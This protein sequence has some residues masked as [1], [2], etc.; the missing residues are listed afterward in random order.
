MISVSAAQFRHS[1]CYLAKL[2]DLYLRY[3]KGGQDAPIALA[4]LISECLIIIEKRF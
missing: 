4:G 2:H 1:K 3:Q